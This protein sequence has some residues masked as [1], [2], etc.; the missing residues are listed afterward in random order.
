MVAERHAPG[1][2]DRQKRQ[3]EMPIGELL[4]KQPKYEKMLYRQPQYA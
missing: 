4:P 1:R 3:N 2:D